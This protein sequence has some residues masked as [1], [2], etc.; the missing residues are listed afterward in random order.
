MVTVDASAVD[1]QRVGRMGEL[2][3]E[4]ELLARGWLAGNFNATTGNSAGW[5][6]FAFKGERSVKLRVKAKRPGAQVFR[7]WPR[8]TAAS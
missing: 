6:L 2:V 8:R 3:V 4:L 7:W 5:D 1:T